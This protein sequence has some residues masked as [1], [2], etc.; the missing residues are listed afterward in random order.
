M[1]LLIYESSDPDFLDL[2][3]IEMIKVLAGQATVAIRNAMLYREVPLISLIEP[4]MQKRGGPAAHQPQPPHD[5]AVVAAA[6]L[7]FLVFA[8]CRC[9]L[10]EMP[11]WRRSIWSPLPRRWTATLKRLCA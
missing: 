1:G 2:P 8:R 11:S 9:A 3:H 7:L 6:V 5:Y 10:P 4:L